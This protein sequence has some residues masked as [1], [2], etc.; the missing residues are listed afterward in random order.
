MVL[1]FLIFLIQKHSLRLIILTTT[2]LYNKQSGSTLRNINF[3]LK[4]RLLITFLICDC[5]KWI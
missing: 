4:V 5:S 1:I 3:N 2:L